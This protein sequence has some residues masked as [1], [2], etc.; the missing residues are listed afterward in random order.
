MS[1]G[2]N[3]GAGGMRKKVHCTAGGGGSP[4]ERMT[5]ARAVCEMSGWCS[6]R[7]ISTLLATRL[8]QDG[9]GRP[10]R[11]WL[12]SI[13]LQLR[14]GECS[15]PGRSHK[16]SWTTEA[17]SWRLQNLKGPDDDACLQLFSLLGCCALHVVCWESNP[18]NSKL[19]RCQD[20]D[21]DGLRRALQQSTQMPTGG[22]CKCNKSISI[23]SIS[24]R[25]IGI[26]IGDRENA[27]SD[28]ITL[29]TDM[30]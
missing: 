19:V 3:S 13:S 1:L 26:A 2:F 29:Y 24:I 4:A 23:Y 22:L 16:K 15:A 18:C 14:Q 11:P 28:R 25:R 8:H 6:S 5:P 9:S 17:H 30:R 10:L 20:A 21:A 27:K 12:S 7:G